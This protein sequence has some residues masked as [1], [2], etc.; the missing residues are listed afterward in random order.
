MQRDC[1]AA[2]TWSHGTKAHFL[3]PLGKLSAVVLSPRR[4]RATSSQRMLFTDSESGANPPPSFKALG[5]VYLLPC[6]TA[7]FDG[8]V[9]QKAG[10][11][12]V[13]NVGQGDISLM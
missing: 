12:V 10:C 7:E 2:I 3:G 9:F 13:G 11:G 8:A 4:I 6:L 1:V 5:V